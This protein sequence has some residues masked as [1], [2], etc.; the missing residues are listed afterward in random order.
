MDQSVL[1]AGCKQRAKYVFQEFLKAATL[2]VSHEK[3]SLVLAASSLL[4]VL[5]QSPWIEQAE[6]T[7]IGERSSF[8]KKSIQ[9][10]NLIFSFVCQRNVLLIAQ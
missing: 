3:W 9:F 7:F 10:N 6:K 1:A 2:W 5:P 8:Q 4:L